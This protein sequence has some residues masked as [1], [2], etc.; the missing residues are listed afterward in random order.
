MAENHSRAFWQSHVAACEASGEKLA[1]CC[2][3]LRLNYWT[4]RELRKRL[5]P[6]GAAATSKRQA[7]VPVMVRASPAVSPLVLELRV[8]GAVFMAVCGCRLAAFEW[9]KSAC[10]TCLIR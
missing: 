1:D 7:L 2:R 5:R 9:C 4:F 6:I 8:G 10:E 3:R